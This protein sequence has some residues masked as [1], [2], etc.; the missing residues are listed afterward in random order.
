MWSLVLFAIWGCLPETD[1]LCKG[2]NL[3]MSNASSMYL[4]LAAG[5][6]IGGVISWWIYNR[7][8]KTSLKQDHI[9]KRID[10]LEQKNSHILL[11]LE[12]FAN[13]HDEL[14]NKI[15]ALNEDVLHFD[16]K[17]QSIIEK[18]K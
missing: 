9:I 7:Q 14:L 6:A 15:L 11:H 4:G 8:N 17:L 5:A 18:Q 16:E 2:V 13:R 10:N 1:P 3:E 12:Q